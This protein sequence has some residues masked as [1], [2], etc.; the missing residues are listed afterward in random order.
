M[1]HD[2]EAFIK[3]DPHMVA[4]ERLGSAAPSAPIPAGITAL[5]NPELYR[6][7]DRVAALPKGLWDKDAVSTYE[8][9]NTSDGMFAHMIGQLGLCMDTKWFIRGGEKLELVEEVTIYVSRLLVSVV[10]AQCEGNWK[11]IHERMVKVMEAC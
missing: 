5:G 2:H 8:F 1:L 11:G 10:K 4:F 6:V 3:C 9:T 7:T